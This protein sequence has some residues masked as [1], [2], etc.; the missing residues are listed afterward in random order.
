[1]KRMLTIAFAF[2]IA[3]GGAAAANADK[4]A[5]PGREHGL[6]T[7]FF[8]GQK[9]GHEKQKNG[10]KGE[11]PGPFE[12]LLDNAPDGD[13]DNDTGGDVADLYQWC[14]QYGIGG[15]EDNGR[16]DCT[17]T[18]DDP[19]TQEDES[20]AECDRDTQPGPDRG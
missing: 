4:P 10:E 8:N 1:M 11:Y 12:G 2:A 3:L 5:D 16:W 13:D 9:N 14:Q 20:N 18:E 7:A 19:T 17:I 6:C 15:N